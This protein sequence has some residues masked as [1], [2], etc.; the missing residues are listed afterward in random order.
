MIDDV[1]ANS[2]RSIGNE[3]NSDIDRRWFW[4]RVVGG[5][6]G[7]V[8]R[9]VSA[10]SSAYAVVVAAAASVVMSLV[11]FPVPSQSSVADP[12]SVSFHFST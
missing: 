5:P 3:N 1:F 6:V 11:P 12:A 9:V 2:D 7:A 4:W 10:E 8:G